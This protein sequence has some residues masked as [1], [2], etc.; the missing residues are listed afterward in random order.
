MSIE[1]AYNSW[2]DLYDTNAN[3]TRDL[4]Q[5]VTIKT[6]EKYSYN[7]VL[8]LGSGT[9]KNTQYLMRKASEIICFDF[10]DKMLAKAKKKIVSSKVQFVKTDLNK[11]WI[12]S[13]NYFDLITSSLT[14]EHIQN[15]DKI[16]K[17]AHDKLKQGGK[18]FICE[19]HPIKQYL[20][21]KAQFESEKG[22]IQNLEVYVHHVSDYLN[23]AHKFGFQLI[24]LKEW[25]DELGDTNQL[26]DI[27]RLI[28]FVFE[29]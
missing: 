20:G 12:A 6:L 29:K 17:Q 25:F 8:E 22:I 9:G 4:D 16:F 27:P 2:A 15:L 11:K 5:E 7:K 1:K 3:K 26:Q 10:S 24:E 14:L 28:S 19:L 18:F 23:A 21:S 13:N